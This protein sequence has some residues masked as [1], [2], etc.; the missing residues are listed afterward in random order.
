MTLH[1]VP[2]LKKE[3]SGETTCDEKLDDIDVGNTVEN[4][5]ET[6]YIYFR[7]PNQESNRQKSGT[8]V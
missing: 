6:G 2:M 1:R 4:S 5:Q 7:V 3:S 8:T